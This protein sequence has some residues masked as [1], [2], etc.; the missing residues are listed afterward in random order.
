MTRPAA[1]QQAASTVAGRAGHSG[2]TRDTASPQ[3]ASQRLVALDLAT[4]TG[5]AV[6][7]LGTGRILDSGVHNLIPKSPIPMKFQLLAQLMGELSKQHDPAAVIV[8]APNPFGARSMENTRIALGLSTHAEYLANALGLDFLQ[9]LSTSTLK[10]HAA[11][12]I[13][14]PKA[15]KGKAQA[16]Q[17]ATSLLGR[18]PVD[19][20]EADAVVLAHWASQNA[21]EHK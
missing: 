18:K 9:P 3:I 7:E 12:L 6:I 10:K 4:K 13:G 11:T 16:I 1:R 19:D 5:Y 15:T 17:A 8:E 21:K 20:N 2:S 14:E